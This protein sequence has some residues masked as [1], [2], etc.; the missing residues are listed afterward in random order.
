MQWFAHVRAGRF[1][2]MLALGVLGLALCAQPAAAGNAS[3]FQSTKAYVGKS[4]VHQNAFD[5]KYTARDFRGARTEVALI[6]RNAIVARAALVK[7]QPSNARGAKGKQ[8]LLRYWKLKR[9][10]TAELAL[11]VEASASGDPVTAKRHLK[12]FDALAN[13]AVGLLFVGIP[14]L[15]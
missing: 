5:D 12:S 2:A 13:K 4:A 15:Q 6:A 9:A 1:L 3:I 14:Y 8:A 11:A 10:A 7:Q